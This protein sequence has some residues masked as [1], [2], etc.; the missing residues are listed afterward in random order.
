MILTAFT[1]PGILPRSRLRL[2]DGRKELKYKVN[3]L[4][5][6]TIYKNCTSCNFVRP[7][8]SNHCSDC[9]NCVERFDHHCPW[10][11]NCVA[12]RNYKYFYIFILLLNI[13][14]VYMIVFSVAYIA[15]F[16]KSHVALYE[17]LALQNVYIFFK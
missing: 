1:D 17:A 5:Y 4:G 2:D 10:L 16:L 14:T 15:V 12:K 7:L 13:L 11:G 8:R 6:L 9:N 3:Q